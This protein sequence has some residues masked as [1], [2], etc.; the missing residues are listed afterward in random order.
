MKQT[1]LTD[2]DRD[3][4]SGFLSMRVLRAGG[5][6]QIPAQP[7]V[8]VVLRD[9]TRR[10]AFLT[11][12]PAGHFKG[13]DPTLPVEELRR[14]WVPEARVLY[15]GKAGGPGSRVSLR[16]RVRTYLRHGGGARAAHWGGRAVWQLRDSSKL[17]VAW[18]S[19]PRGHPRCVERELLD[20]FIEKHGRRPFANRTR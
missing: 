17:L 9:S 7:G 2:L 1:A 5:G 8:Y 20:L 13:R 15:I 19:L 11:R 3:D 10:P 4:F 14:A 18:L 16:S 6:G 12:S